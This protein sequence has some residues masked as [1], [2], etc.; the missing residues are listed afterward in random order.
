MRRINYIIIHCT[1]TR[2]GQ[3]FTLDDVE[4]WHRQRGWR[5][6][7]YHYV[8]RLDGTIEKG[9]AEED[10][11]AHCKGH[12]HDSI[13]VCYVGGL[14]SDGRPCDTRTSEQRRA[15]HALVKELRVAYPGAEVVGHRDLPGVKKSCPCFDVPS[16][17]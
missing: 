6:C 16:E 12:N 8:I 3:P 4:C 10:I 5:Q 1:A 13:G 11:G 14:D 15:M 9:R 7:G 2:E 17:F